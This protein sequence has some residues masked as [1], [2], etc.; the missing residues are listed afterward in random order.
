MADRT[1]NMTSPA[2]GRVVEIAD[3]AWLVEGC[4][5]V[6]FPGGPRPGNSFVLRDQDVAVLLYADGCPEKLPRIMAIL[7]RLI[8][9]GASEL[10]VLPAG[11]WGAYPELGDGYRKV[12]MLMPG[13]VQAPQANPLSPGRVEI[14]DQESLL[15]CGFGSLMCKGWPVG[16]FWALPEATGPGLVS[17]Y[18]PQHKLMISGQATLETNPGAGCNS[19]VECIEICR[20]NLEM[21]EQGQILLASDR[22]R[23]SRHWPH[24]LAERGLS[25]LSHPQMA[26]AALGQ[27][28]CEE[29][30]RGWLNYFT[31]LRDEIL[32]AHSRIGDA[33]IREIAG[34]LAK[35]SDPNLRFRMGLEEDPLA[36]LESLVAGVMQESRASRRVEGGR[37]LFSPK[38]KWKFA[39]G[40]DGR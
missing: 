21:A 28:E 26:D 30:Y 31:A 18:D 13:P 35:S 3:Q 23:S 29:L 33:A 36:G 8:E 27:K 32:L 2:P 19:L 4:G 37:V 7:S 5:G 6:G 11:D 9:R 14:L 38:G 12:R 10:V 16:R 39:G 20:R 40:L 17:F 1:K 24:A 15:E 22:W 34:E 25:P